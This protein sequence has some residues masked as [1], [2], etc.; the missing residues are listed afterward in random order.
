MSYDQC[1]LLVKKLLSKQ[2]NLRGG[3]GEPETRKPTHLPGDGN[4]PPEHISFTSTAAVN[5]LRAEEFQINP[6]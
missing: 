4:R 6:E 1:Y 3:E 2:S 5:R